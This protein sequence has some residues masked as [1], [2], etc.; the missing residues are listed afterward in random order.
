MAAGVCASTSFRLLMRRTRDLTHYTHRSMGL[1]IMPISTIGVVSFCFYFFISCV[2]VRVCVN[3]Y[4][5][6]NSFTLIFF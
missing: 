5:T 2:R 6:Y 1:R 3:T 4:T